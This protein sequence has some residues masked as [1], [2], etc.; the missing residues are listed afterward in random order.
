[1][2]PP[3]ITEFD[4]QALVDSHLTW[5]EEKR[6]LQAIRTDP[7]LHAYYL[8]I[9]AQ[10]KLLVAWWKEQ[11]TENKTA[12]STSHEAGVLLLAGMQ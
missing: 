4:V 1:M 5:E 8:Q 2:L 6:V 9:V 7:A 3:I 10:K 11:A 12:K